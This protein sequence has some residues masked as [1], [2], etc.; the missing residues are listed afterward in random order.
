MPYYLQESKVLAATMLYVSDKATIN[1][2]S[3]RL[4]L[5]GPASRCI[6]KPLNQ[7]SMSSSVGPCLALQ[8]SAIDGLPLH[9]TYPAII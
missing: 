8:R 5:P 3:T 4:S 1:K 2:A 7:V 6:T 9:H